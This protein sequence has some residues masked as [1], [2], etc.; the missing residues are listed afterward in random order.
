MT[1]R[2]KLTSIHGSNLIYLYTFLYGK[3]TAGNSYWRYTNADSDIT[4]NNNLFTALPITH[5]N[6]ESTGSLDDGNVEIML[7]SDSELA[8]FYRIDHPSRIVTVTIE[9]KHQDDPEVV[10]LWSGRVSAVN[11]EP[12]QTTVACEPIFSSMKRPALR[13]RFQHGCRHTLYDNRCGVNQDN[14]K[15]QALVQSLGGNTIQITLFSHVV[16]AVGLELI[17]FHG[18][19]AIWQTAEETIVRSIQQVFEEGIIDTIHLD[20]STRELSIGDSVTFHPGCRRT[21]ADCRDVFNNIDNFGG[22][23]YIPHENP[24]TRFG[25][26][27]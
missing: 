21:F 4:I 26:L 19:K 25:S 24:V 12:H 23:P 1:F 11:E 10:K 5:S 15:V 27:G 3:G 13:S 16:A 18:G 20:G 8:E 9:A 14:F 7:G 6:I 22:C 2:N 17:N